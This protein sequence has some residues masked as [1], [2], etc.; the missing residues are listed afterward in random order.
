VQAKR[1][2]TV[3]EREAPADKSI[4]TVVGPSVVVAAK[5]LLSIGM[6]DRSKALPDHV[7]ACSDPDVSTA[8]AALERIRNT[9]FVETGVPTRAVPM[10][11]RVLPHL[12][13]LAVDVSVTIRP[14]IIDVINEAARGVTDS[15]WPIALDSATSA[16]LALLD[17]P[18]PL[19]RR[20]TA[21][22]T[23]A[24]DGNRSLVAL[25]GRLDR[26]TDRVTRWELAAAIVAR[27]PG[28]DGADC[29]V[30]DSD[31]QVWLVAQHAG[32]SPAY[33][34]QLIEAVP[35]AGRWPDR[36][37]SALGRGSCPGGFTGTLPEAMEVL[38]RWRS[39][40]GELLPLLGE[41]LYAH[42][43][44]LRFRAAY[45]LACV[46]PE[47]YADRLAE[48]LDDETPCDH[49]AVADAAVWALARLNDERALSGL[50]DRL[51]EPRS[52]YRQSRTFSSAS[53]QFV[54]ELPAVFEIVAGY[55]PA[56]GLGDAV[57]AAIDRGVHLEL[58]H[59]AAGLCHVMDRWGEGAADA[60]PALRQMM[61]HKYPYVRTAA[62]IALGHIG[63]AATDALPDL[64]AWAGAHSPDAAVAIW[65]ITAD[66]AQ[67]LDMIAETG[68]G[69]WLTEGEGLAELGLLASK[70][71]P[72][73]SGLLSAES[74][75]TR[76]EAAS[77]L[78]RIAADISGVATLTAAAQP[79]ADGHYAPH[80]R[81]ALETLVDIGMA[82]DLL[83]RAILGRP[84]RVRHAPNWRAF[85][86]DQRSCIAAGK[87]LRQ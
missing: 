71:A 42:D 39:V 36:A 64:V 3:P 2:M 34:D 52:S 28:P 58:P 46:D 84:D 59:L 81:A 1:A 55:G 44:A 85:D 29:L 43:P 48:L 24:L 40:T 63:P 15:M 78:W 50:A 31:P 20:A 5:R 9:S 83:A 73:V 62:S 70:F 49:G 12:V 6:G 67:A 7:A 22:L 66:P 77:T 25:R 14:A 69:F 54:F 75:W 8:S 41:S 86:N 74:E 60:V 26:E 18:D 30:D 45:A 56:G 65:R 76:V 19:V 53:N 35:A 33:L 51:Y 79:L 11:V 27:W 17:D 16:L 37:W 57:V 13:R 32:G 10:A 82:N 21:R 23:Y 47:P 38:R 61:R 80:R 68:V 4:W 72:A 87:L